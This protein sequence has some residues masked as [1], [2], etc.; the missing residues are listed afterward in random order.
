[1]VVSIVRGINL[2]FL[3]KM[4]GAVVG[5]GNARLPPIRTFCTYHIAL[6]YAPVSSF[7]L[8]SSFNM[9]Y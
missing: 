1:M 7:L 5:N 9:Q 8:F 3:K 6:H 2:T 4:H